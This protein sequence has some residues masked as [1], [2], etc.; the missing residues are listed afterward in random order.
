[1]TVVTVASAAGCIGGRFDTKTP[2]VVLDPNTRV[3]VDR[4]TG[5]RAG[6]GLPPG[7]WVADL[8]PPALR[9]ATAVAR[10]E[11][12]LKTAANQAAQHGVTALGRHLWSFATD[13]VELQRF[14]SPPMVTEE[15]TLLFAVAAAPGPAGHISV[16]LLIAEPGTSALRADEMGGGPGGSNPA[17]ETYAHPSVATGPCGESWPAAPRIRF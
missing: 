6:K 13:C 3:I 2:A 16:V 4:I 15:R 1:V 7:D 11:Q 17:L 14:R 8:G 10:G 12:T 9:A 5:D